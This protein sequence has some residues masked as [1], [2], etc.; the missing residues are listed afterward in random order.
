MSFTKPNVAVAGTL[1]D[2]APLQENLVALRTYLHDGV[3][4]GD[5]RPSAWVDTRHIQSPVI[6]PIRGLQHGVS[7][8]AGGQSSGGPF[9]RATMATSYLTG[10]K[11][12]VPSWIPVVGTSFKIDVRAPAKLFFHYMWEVVAGP[13]DLANDSPRIT[14]DVDR[15]VAIAPYYGNL[16]TV[17]TNAAQETNN[18]SAGW[19]STE[20][21]PETSYEVHGFG[22][23]DGTLY[24][25]L[26]VGT[27]TF[28]LASFSEVDRVAIINWAVSVE[29]YYI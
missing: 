23:K 24:R 6:D 19:A 8:W 21:S 18:N 27:A 25:D 11:V 29:L 12:G 15:T 13:D 14:D 16:T 10:N 5:I 9:V 1:V 20:R 17:E 22:Q 2:A 3:V 4:T 28:G 26:S 7:G